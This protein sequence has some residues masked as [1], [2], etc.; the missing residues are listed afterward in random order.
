[1]PVKNAGAYLE[2]CLRSIISQTETD[3]ELIAVNDG[4][5][6]NSWQILN[7]FAG[8]DDRITILNNNGSGII[9]ALRMAYTESKG[10]LITRMDADDRMAPQ[11]L[12]VLSQNLVEY[13]K[14]H[15]ATGFVKYFSET[16]LGEGYMKYEQWLNGLTADGSN[17]T[18][19]YKEC[20][21]P[22]PCWM[23]WREDL[24]CCGAFE[25][26]IYPEDYDLC[27]RFYEQN[28]KV[29]PCNDVLHHW[30]DHSTRTSRID[31]HYADNSFLEL[32]L[33]WFL[34]LDHNPKRPLML[35]GAGAKGKALAKQ[36]VENGVQFDWVCNNPKK[37]GH[38]IYGVEMRSEQ[39]L[40][41]MENPQ[42][43]VSIANPQ[44]QME[45]KNLLGDRAFF[46]C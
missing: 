8:Q 26:N 45:L 31:P 10:K 12:E 43:I 5:T 33:N 30:R 2:E 46:F 25:P 34:Q 23:V 37:I 38:I 3:W 41:E 36:L 14:G 42:V 15:L 16:A 22:S 9:D 44:E 7:D 28:L 21:I 40:S 27:F 32:K 11:K 20:V 6:D 24:D 4:S 29:V 35:W 17:Y 13:G 39:L 18:D 1:M 19:I